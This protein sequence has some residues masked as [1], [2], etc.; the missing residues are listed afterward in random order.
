MLGLYACFR[1][2]C[3]KFTQE[4]F[5]PYIVIAC[6]QSE[7]A[8]KIETGLMKAFSRDKMETSSYFINFKRPFDVTPFTFFILYLLYK[9]FSLALKIKGI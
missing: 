4:S 5:N 1:I 7:Q 6:L 9:I 2:A 3:F 8:K